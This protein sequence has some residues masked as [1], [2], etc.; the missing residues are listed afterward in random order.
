M[1]FYKA[2]HGVRTLIRYDQKSDIN[3]TLLLRIADCFIKKY[4]NNDVHQDDPDKEART[5]VTQAEFIRHKDQLYKFF[6][7]ITQN[8]PS[9]YKIWRLIGRIKLSLKEPFSVVKDIKMKEIRAI[10]GINWHVEI[11]TCELVERTL[12]ELVNDIFSNCPAD[13]E[14]KQFVRNTSKTIAETLHRESKV[15]QV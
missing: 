13:D 11:E 9:D 4:I 5:A 3:P 7:H 10:M 2:V 6:D 15:P 1:Q 14:E 12:I 8:L